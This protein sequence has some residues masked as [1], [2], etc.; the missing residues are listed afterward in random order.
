MWMVVCWRQVRARTILKRAPQL[1]PESLKRPRPAYVHT[2]VEIRMMVLLAL[3][4][5]AICGAR[6]QAGG[7]K[8]V[9]F[10]FYPYGRAGL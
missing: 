4:L 1:E 2:G 7:E 10:P 6:R 5:M 9:L 3:V 8:L